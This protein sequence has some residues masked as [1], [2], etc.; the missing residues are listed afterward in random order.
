VPLAISRAGN[1]VA[2]TEH[3]GLIHFD[4]EPGSTYELV[5]GPTTQP[6]GG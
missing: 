4:T 1:P 2:T 6:D 5:A 3:D